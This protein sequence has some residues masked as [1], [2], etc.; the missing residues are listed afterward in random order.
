MKTKPPGKAAA[1]QAMLPD[2][3]PFAYR[4]QSAVVPLSKLSHNGKEKH[5]VILYYP[6]RPR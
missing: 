6:V 1:C 2:M 5:P 3:T 4:T